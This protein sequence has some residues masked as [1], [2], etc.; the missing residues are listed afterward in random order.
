MHTYYADVLSTGVRR[1]MFGSEVAYYFEVS[2][3][4]HTEFSLADIVLTNKH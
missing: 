2:I 1:G 3:R 4:L